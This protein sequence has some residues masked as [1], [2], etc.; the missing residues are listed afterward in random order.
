MEFRRAVAAQRALSVFI[1]E[2][3]LRTERSQP[4]L[5]KS[6]LG[7]AAKAVSQK[8]RHQDSIYVL[9]FGFLGVI[10]PGVDTPTALRVSSRFSIGLSEASRAGEHFDFEIHAVNYPEHAKSL[11]D[12]EQVVC[13]HLPE[14]EPRAGLSDEAKLEA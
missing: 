13:S 8:L 14:P 12:L 4:G 9:S 11:H 10:L 1:V 5:A 6:A 3:K 2:V 7:D